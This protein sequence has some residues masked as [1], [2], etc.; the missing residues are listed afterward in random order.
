MDKKE[1]EN[2]GIDYAVGLA[3]FAKKEELYHK[4]LVKFKEDT[5]VY[6]AV[7]AFEQG[8]Y[9]K[10][11][12]QIHALKGLSGT[13]GFSMLYTKTSTVVADLRKGKCENLAQ[14][15]KEIQGECERLIQ[16]IEL[17]IRK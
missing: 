14:Q 1:L 16:V 10:V 2:A 6:E 9:Q 11:L 15:L 5:H 7:S 12:E 8:E 17:E 4:Y 3:H 13:L